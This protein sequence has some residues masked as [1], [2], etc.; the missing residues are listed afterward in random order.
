[1]ADFDFDIGIVGAGAAG[2]TV[3][4]GSAQLGA[5]TLLVEKEEKLGGDCLHYGCVP[6]K[7]LI[8]TAA[9]YHQMKNAE[10]YGLP[11][12]E[13]PPVDFTQVRDRITSVIDTIQTHDSQ[14]RFCSL[15]VRVES[16]R[17][18]F[19]DEH[20]VALNG[21]TVSARSWVI[22]TGSFP[23]IPPLEGLSDTPHI[24]SRD[25]FFLEKLPSSMIVLGAGPIAVEMAQAFCRLG[26]AVT[27]VQR[28]GQILSKEDK[29]MADAVMDIMEAEGVTFYLSA[30]IRSIRDNGLQREVAVTTKKGKEV[31]LAAQSILVAM[32]RKANVDGL[33]LE[34]LDIAFTRKGITVDRRLRTARK[35][36]Y[37]AGDVTGTHQFTHA[38]GYE[39]GVVLGNAVFHLPRKTD[40]T[41]LPWCTYTEP[42][43]A[44]IGMNEKR[45]Q[46]AGISYTVWTEAFKDND[47]ALAEAA[48]AGKIKMLLDEKE[49]PI[50]VQILGLHAGEVV[51]HWIAAMCGRVKLSTLAAAVHP[52][53]TLA[54]INKRVAGT[55]LAKKLFSDKVTK[56]LKLLFHLKGRAGCD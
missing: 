44:S 20:T 50:G 26:T 38:A 5:K 24:T 23:D 1:M 52:Y 32:G 10:K 47:R 54:E 48:P 30:Q 56:G 55:V 42:E 35:H 12:L 37:A 31:T 49:R 27:V 8:K 36:I 28:S 6:S 4:A 9:V 43:L 18:V 39:G 51:N 14:E 45:A 13:V 25:I 33:G 29:E 17:P 22:A 40:Y 46:Q 3:A 34:R 53:P 7:T 2:L 21:K 11:R 19:V 41:L 15:G 16:G